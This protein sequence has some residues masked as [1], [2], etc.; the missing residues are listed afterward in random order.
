MCNVP[1]PYF[2]SKAQ[3]FGFT[4]KVV[5]LENEKK[6]TQLTILATEGKLIKGQGMI[7]I[8]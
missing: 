2:I 7:L 8:F 4:C 1:L 3:L 5:R 6:N